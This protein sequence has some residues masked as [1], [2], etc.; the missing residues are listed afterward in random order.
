M[1]EEREQP[2]DP[3]P[4]LQSVFTAGQRA[5]TLCGAS[6]A[7][8]P[9]D[10]SANECSAC[11]RAQHAEHGVTSGPLP[12][13][14]RSVWEAWMAALREAA[15][16][17]ALDR[18]ADGYRARTAVSKWRAVTAHEKATLDKVLLGILRVPK[19]SPPALCL[20][21][22]SARCPASAQIV[23]V[24]ALV[25]AHNSALVLQRWHQVLPTR[26]SEYLYGVQACLRHT[27][28]LR[29]LS[30]PPR[31]TLP[32]RAKCGDGT[33]WTASGPHCSGNGW[34]R[35]WQLLNAS[36]PTAGAHAA[37]DRRSSAWPTRWPWRRPHSVLCASGTRYEAAHTRERPMDGVVLT[38]AWAGAVDAREAQDG[39]D[40][41]DGG[42]RQPAPPHAAGG[43]RAATAGGEQAQ[44]SPVLENGLR[45]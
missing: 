19:S 24:R 38:G 11:T 8:G 36:T 5:R 33:R 14:P 13:A 15:A 7:F 44:R 4:A 17:R 2:G 40:L 34:R 20:H 18:V 9:N 32:R 43:P 10:I 30:W 39:R 28:A 41:S 27:R 22:H 45:I 26:P 23:R 35:L 25:R 42:Q 12:C 3:R 1:L 16:Q 29:R 6:W 37:H 21:S 31:P